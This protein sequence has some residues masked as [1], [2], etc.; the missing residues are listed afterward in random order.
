MDNQEALATLGTQD[1]GRRQKKNKT[2]KRYI[3]VNKV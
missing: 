1:R 3:A 2:K